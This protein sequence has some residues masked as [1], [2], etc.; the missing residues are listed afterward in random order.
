MQ[1]SKGLWPIAPP[2][3]LPN[4]NS[5]LNPNPNPKT[6]TNP[7]TNPIKKLT[8][9]LFGEKPKRHPNIG[10]HKVII[11]GYL[12]VLTDGDGFIRGP[13]PK[14]DVFIFWMGLSQSVYDVCMCVCCR[15]CCRCIWFNWCCWKQ[16]LCLLYAHQWTS[17]DHVT[18]LSWW[19]CVE[20]GDPPSTSLCNADSPLCISVSCAVMFHGFV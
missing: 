11:I 13:Y 8:R 2:M 20:F 3:S 17:W 9:T 18:S 12:P 10:Q 7:N 14:N 5:N 1:S 4:P 6:K 19:R 15:L 16:Q